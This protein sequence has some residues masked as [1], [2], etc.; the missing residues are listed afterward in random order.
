MGPDEELASLIADRLTHERL[1]DADRRDEVST[2]IA[3]GTATADDWRF[4]IEIGP[5]G[6]KEG[7]GNAED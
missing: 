3:A 5:A 1:I 2:K 4:W 7:I 6:Q